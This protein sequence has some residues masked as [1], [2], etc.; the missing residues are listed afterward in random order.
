M[1]EPLKMF[2]SPALVRKLAEG[3][4]RVTPKF[5]A[6]AFITEATMGLD[7]FEHAPLHRA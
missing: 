6:R 7:D 4:E 2:F 3:L 5:P 1:P